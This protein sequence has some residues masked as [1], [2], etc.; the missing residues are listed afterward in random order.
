MISVDIL[1]SMKIK[2]SA[3][4]TA[5]MLALFVTFLWSTSFIIIKLGLKEIPPLVFAGLRYSIAF[6]VLL[7]F[8][9]TNKNVKK[10][11]AKKM[12]IDSNFPEL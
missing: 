3:H 8:L 7:P 4:I 1:V 9:F 11:I 5:I 12:V 2:F 10:V 6:V